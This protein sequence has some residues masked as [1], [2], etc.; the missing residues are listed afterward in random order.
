MSRADTD[1]SQ[2]GL[3]MHRLIAELLPIP[4]SITGDGLRQTLARLRPLLPDL[5]IHEVP[6]GT[7]VFDWIVPDEW[8][9]RDAWIKGPDGRTVVALRDSSLHV[10]NYSLPIRRTLPLSELRPHLHTLPDRPGW[11]PYRT[12]YYEPAWGFCLAHER[13]ADL[14]EGD[15]EVCIDSTLAPGSLTYGE[16]FIPGR[17]PDEVLISCHICH[18]ALA[19]DNLSGVALVTELARHL[20]G[21]G[22]RQLSYRFLLVPGTIGAIAWLA[23]NPS[24]WS[25]IRHGLVVAC[26]GDPGP[27]HY[28]RTRQ[29]NADIDRAVIAALRHRPEGLVIRDFDPFGFDERQYNSPGINLMVGRLTRTP[30]GEYPEYHT[31]ADNLALVRPEALAGSLSAYI[32]V[33]DALEANRRYLNLQ[34]RCEPQLGRRGLY[35]SLGGAPSSSELKRAMLWL[36]NL[37]DGT[38]DLLA[39]ALRSDLS[40]RLLDTAARLLVEHG[41]LAAVDPP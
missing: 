17:Q 22:T 32:D 13:L 33:F 2:T 15:Y 10:L 29:G 20:A 9:L 14:P 27:F 18:P 31:S 6:S 7:Q 36:L 8:N 3:R 21:Q 12:S 38:H 16:L 28:K 30:D 4:R 24:A 35:H 11:I 1:P 37:S 40:P 23:R 34:P 25:R 5:R 41:L 39:I 19:N 26:V